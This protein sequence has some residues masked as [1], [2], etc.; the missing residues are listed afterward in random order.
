MAVGESASGAMAG[1]FAS[2]IR[3]SND[4]AAD[5]SRVAGA[6]AES[7]SDWAETGA[8]I[9]AQARDHAAYARENSK[10]AAEEVQR[11]AHAILSQMHE[12][13]DELSKLSR[14]LVEKV[15]TQSS[16]LRAMADG[17]GALTQA[18]RAGAGQNQEFMNKLGE[19]ENR[20]AALE[21]QMRGLS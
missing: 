17:L 5:A 2:D 12:R 19:F 10:A 14:P 7:A 15:D 1:L 11:A 8:R 18:V 20:L 21:K 13:A 3:R 6:A 4:R 16:S 9:A